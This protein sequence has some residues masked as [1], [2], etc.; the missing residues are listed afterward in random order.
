MNTRHSIQLFIILIAIA[1]MGIATQSEIILDR[2][3]VDITTSKDSLM[4]KLSFSNEGGSR[5][6]DDLKVS[7]L[8]EKY[9]TLATVIKKVVLLNGQQI[10]E[11]ALPVSANTPP[12]E[13]CVLRI[14]L[15]GQTWLKPLG[16]SPKG[17]ELQVIGQR[18][19][20]EG[21]KSLVR[22]IAN[23]TSGAPVGGVQV[24]A[25]MLINGDSVYETSSITDADGSAEL[26]FPADNNKQ[27]D[28]ELKISAQ[29]KLGAQEISSTIAVKPGVKVFLTTDKPVYQPKQTI[30]IRALAAH[31]ATS[32]PLANREVTLEVYDGRGNK[33][34]KSIKTTSEFGVVSADFPLADE[35]NQGD[36]LVKT[37][38]GKSATEKGVQVFEYVLPKFRVDVKNQKEFYSPGDVVKGELVAR[39]FFGKPV[40]N[41][42]VKITANCFDVGFNEFETVEGKTNDEGKFEY[43]FTIPEK[44]VGQPSFQGNTIIQMDVRV[45]DSADHEEQKINTFHVA[46]EPVEVELVPEN[47]RLV[48]GVVNEIFAI[49]SYPD[50]SVAKPKLK[51]QSEWLSENVN[52]QCDDN[53]IATFRLTPLRNTNIDLTIQ[54]ELD[55]DSITL[56]KELPAAPDE[57]RIL[58]RPNKGVYRVG[59]V[60]TVDV[61]TP[62]KAGEAVYLDI[63]KN[64]QTMLTHTLRPKNGKASIKQAI[65][66]ELA[67]TLELNAYRIRNDG[68]M[69]RDTKRVVALR[70]DDLQIE[71]KPDL[72][73]YEPGQPA[74]LLIAVKDQDGAPVQAALGMHIVDESVYSLSEKE[75]GLAKVFFAIERELLNPKI[76]IHGFHLDKAIPLTAKLLQESDSLSRALLAKLDAPSPYGL[77]VNTVQKKYQK[78]QQNLQQFVNFFRTNGLVELEPSLPLG[79]IVL[80]NDL[81][82]QNL[83]LNDPWG[84]PYVTYANPDNGSTVLASIGVDQKEKTQDDVKVPYFN[85]VRN[86]LFFGRALNEVEMLR[87]GAV[88]RPLKEG[89]MKLEVAK[90]ANVDFA[91]AKELPRGGMGN[92]DFGFEA[93][94]DR[95]AAVHEAPPG[96]A[97]NVQDEGIGAKVIQDMFVGAVKTNANQNVYFVGQSEPSEDFD[98]AMRYGFPLPELKDQTADAPNRVQVGDVVPFVFGVA[99]DAGD[100]DYDDYYAQ[101]VKL[102]EES[103]GPLFINGELSEE[104]VMKAAERYIDYKGGDMNDME[105]IAK[106]MEAS[107]N[108]IA[109]ATNQ[110]AA[111]YNKPNERAVRVRR[112][113][114]ETLYYA[115]E[116]IT[117]ENGESSIEL[118]MADSITT[119][120][121]SAMANAKSGALGD[122][123]SAM[124]VFKPFFI[125]IN[126]PTHLT[127][128]DEVTIPVS[129]YN[130]L[131]KPQT[132]DVSLE[133]SGWFELLNGD[134]KKTINV[135]AN[136]VTSVSYPIQAKSLG[137]Q[138]ITVFGWGS[139][140]ADAVGREIEV[141]PNGEPQFITRNGRL[142]S[143]VEERLS[144]PDGRLQNADKLL[145]KIYPGVFSQV[146]EGMDAILRMPNGCFE[147]TS[148][149]TYPNLLALNYM[150]ASKR[151]TPAIEMKAKEYINLGYQRLLTFEI[152]GGGFSVFG[153]APA[154]RVLSAYGLL[155]FSDMNEVYPIDANVI[156]RTK[157]WL[158]G[159]RKADGSWDPDDNYAHAEMWK[160]IQDN[161]VL[162]TAY[163]A[164]ALAQTGVGSELEITKQ[165]LINHADEAKDAYTLAILTNAMIA[166]DP[167]GE[168]TKDCL[169]R[170][171]EMAEVDNQ[172]V[173]WKSEASMSFAR[174]EHAWVE[175]TAWAALALIDNGRYPSEL[176]KALNW[177]IS[178][179]TSNGTWSTTHGTV[180]ALKALVKSIGQRT[181]VA[182]GTVAIQV[183]DEVVD[184]LEIKP[185]YS[186]VFRQIDAGNFL[187][188]GENKVTLALDGE[189]SMLYQ[190]VGKYYENWDAALAQ[191]ASGEQAFD[192]DV[193]YDR[194]E[195]RRNDRVTCQVTAKNNSPQRADMVMID[196]GVPPGFRVERPDLDAYVNKGVIEKFTIMSRQLLIYIES[197]DAG[198]SIEIDIPMKATLPM[199]AKAPESSMYEYYNPEVKSISTPQD[200]I[201]D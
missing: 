123:T 137:T 31:P 24:K 201:V 198:K 33:V 140:D 1:W 45:T 16:E 180:L 160:S 98:G 40:D 27:G 139:E 11:V 111:A 158:L 115:P 57:D 95:F 86:K 52:V 17:L 20:T 23:N 125:D 165:Y 9:E 119:W 47:G 112:Y 132:V 89:V 102:F 91:Q 79:E 167:K 150:Q 141:R 164:L 166:I 14:D 107:I 35:V 126:L 82:I 7:L 85:Q 194:T 100:V 116:L 22:V 184:T 188:D 54:A 59:D 25:E 48:A 121:M 78:A 76:E 176:G 105:A 51:I 147:Q 46:V 172:N 161:K 200:I 74:K 8:G 152:S 4:V 151:I 53:G 138:T 71:I 110:D 177:L 43:E 154:T 192:I 2:S 134:Y 37:I 12:I 120:R 64:N 34:F 70:S 69:I 117:D 19:W 42:N 114:P 58:I 159:Q 3:A 63:V 169:D 174:G 106:A 189:G 124:K 130:Y 6:I 55:G 199:T 66:L 157:N 26:L 108:Q 5:R 122:A 186:D 179:K 197:M 67:G 68:N 128:N 39:Y 162:A 163:I 195:L 146:V 80:K 135:A 60:M 131:D 56:K 21:A 178:Q 32:K 61:Y 94:A 129:V 183:N 136:E 103:D 101:E 29:S 175:T 187:H 83:P 41:G 156:Q 185:E 87:R 15:M 153:Q 49:A 171:V 18:E 75:P 144:F 62:D 193:E 104:A 73:E 30:H 92:I 81:D 84:N 173:Y 99:D 96:V 90:G 181:D 118:A 133:K 190:V 28:Y 10:E 168:A 113:F 97:S 149:T 38:C 182:S 196:V 65:D 142:N 155:E 93:K 109:S 88:V 143:A 13:R 77:F 145:I 191:Q 36:Y 170:L 50:G 148:S 127:R 72:D 44:L